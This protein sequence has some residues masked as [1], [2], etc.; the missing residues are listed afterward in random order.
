[1]TRSKH[2]HCLGCRDHFA[3]SASNGVDA[4]VIGDGPEQ[5]QCF[6]KFSLNLGDVLFRGGGGH[7]AISRRCTPRSRAAKRKIRRRPLRRVVWTKK[8]RCRRRMIERAFVEENLL[9]AGPFLDLC[10]TSLA[11]GAD[12]PI[13]AL[14]PFP[15]GGKIGE[16]RRRL[17]FPAS[18]DEGGPPV[19]EVVLRAVR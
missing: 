9:R 15:S 12:R 8:L 4:R 19:W 7:P 13:C 6:I 14:H 10:P 16:S 18:E 11:T 3:R 1:M 2:D 5:C 17:L